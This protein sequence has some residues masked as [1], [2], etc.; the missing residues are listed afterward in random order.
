VEAQRLALHRKRTKMTVAGSMR[1]AS[2]DGYDKLKP[3]SFQVYGF[4]DG[5]SRYILQLY[6][7]ID[8]SI[9]VAVNKQYLR[10]VR[11]LNSVSVLVRSDKETETLLM[12]YSHIQLRRATDPDLPFKD[13]YSFGISTRNIRNES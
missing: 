6:I 2:A 4:I 1:V 9:A 8:N 5:Y 12:A 13:A 7:D 11:E 10:M 3:W